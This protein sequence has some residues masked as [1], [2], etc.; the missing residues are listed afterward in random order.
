M[1]FEIRG[2]NN[3]YIYYNKNQGLEF[4]KHLLLDPVTKVTGL[5]QMIK[6]SA[7]LFPDLKDCE[8]FSGIVNGHKDPYRELVANND[9]DNVSGT[10]RP[11]NGTNA[12][13]KDPLKKRR[14]IGFNMLLMCAVLVGISFAYRIGNHEANPQPI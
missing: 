12:L 3:R 13:K 9:G 1:G 6:E 4:I 2:M 11:M 14:L 7:D 5:Q 8:N 10:H